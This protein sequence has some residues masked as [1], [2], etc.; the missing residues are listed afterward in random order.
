M[1]LPDSV[2]G[3]HLKSCI[4]FV[5]RRNYVTYLGFYGENTMNVIIRMDVI[6]I[7]RRV[8]LLMEILL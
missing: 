1:S 6:E 4:F 3:M 8:I 5:I 7:V 2:L